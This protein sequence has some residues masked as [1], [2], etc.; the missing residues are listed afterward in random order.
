[1]GWSIINIRYLCPTLRSVRPNWTHCKIIL[2]IILLLTSLQSWA[3]DLVTFGMFLSSI[4]SCGSNISVT[5][6]RLI[7]KMTEL[8][9]SRTGLQ[10]QLAWIHS[11]GTELKQMAIMSRARMV[12]DVQIIINSLN[13]QKFITELLLPS[14]IHLSNML[15][16]SGLSFRMLTI[17]CMTFRSSS[18]SF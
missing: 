9:R 4:R 6:Y 7:S 5:P 2:C 13:G 18:R 12:P 15:G 10:P 14:W 11:R 8:T 17:H 1:M 3:R 16:D